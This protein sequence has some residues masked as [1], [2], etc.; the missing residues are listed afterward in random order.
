MKIAL[1]GYG[2]MGREI[3]KSAIAKGHEIVLKLGSADMDFITTDT[4]ADADIA[5]EFSTPHS[6]VSNIKNC[7][8]AGIPVVV[9]T[10]GWY[11]NL[12]F[13]KSLCLKSGKSMLWAS[14]FSPGVNILFELNR[15]LASL[16][17]AQ[18]TYKASVGE[19]HH[20]KKL[21][22]PSGTAITI[23]NDIVSKIH[24]LN[25]WEPMLKDSGF[26]PATLPVWSERT[27]EV[28]GTHIISYES[29]NDRIE[30]RHEAFNRK[31]FADG[32]VMAAEWLKGKTGFFTM[33]DV[34]DFN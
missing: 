14:N 10:T 23:A 2:K 21:D 29:A 15:K 6:A 4:F 27:G 12:E 3:E 16:M 34:L 22:S 25:Q 9:G 7:F 33:T 17:N 28:P 26:P 8:D 1:I 30:L 20:V 19:I 11:D 31:G 5:I 24:R 32:A 18:T 13:I